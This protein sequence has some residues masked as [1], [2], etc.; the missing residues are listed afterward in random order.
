MS[1][2]KCIAAM[3]ASQPLG[4]HTITRRDPTENDVSIEIKFAGICHSD[5]HTGRDEW[6][7][8]IYPFVPGH[9]IGS[10]IV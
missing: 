3:A 2:V 5:I 8:A 10:K 6:G 4:P 9:E 1:E 7:A